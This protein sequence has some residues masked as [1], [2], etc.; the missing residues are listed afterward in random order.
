LLRIDG[1][2]S[3]LW[4]GDP[5]QHANPY[6]DVMVQIQANG[7]PNSGIFSWG[8][9]AA[10]HAQVSLHGPQ[11]STREIMVVKPRK[12]PEKGM[13]IVRV[14]VNSMGNE[15]IERQVVR[16]HGGAIVASKKNMIL[17]SQYGQP[18]QLGLTSDR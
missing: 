17:R 16:Q 5:Y 8:V 18:V 12:P 10:A 11:V 13:R 15:T 7:M 1:Y 3:L 14:V 2:R 4:G 6:R 9:S